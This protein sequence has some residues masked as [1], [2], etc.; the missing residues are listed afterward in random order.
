MTI[1]SN[2]IL[3]L[4]A[5]GWIARYLIDSIKTIAPEQ[6]IVGTYRNNKPF[7]NIKSEKITSGDFYEVKNLIIETNPYTVVN[8]TRGETEADL[9]FHQELTKYLAQNGIYYVYASSSNATDAIWN[10]PYTESSEGNAKSDYGIFK[11][12]CEKVLRE[13]SNNYVAFRFAATHGFAPNRTSRT[14]IFLQKLYAGEIVSVNG[15]IF[16]NR[17]YISDLTNMMAALMF[18]KAQGIIHLGTIDQ[19]EEFEFLNKLALLFGYKDQVIPVAKE[20]NLYVSALP[21]KMFDYLDSSYRL[22]EKDTFDKLINVPE[23]QKYWKN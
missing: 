4:G 23:F 2:N 20:E 10:N 12:R 18:K 7:H 11:A 14:E 1:V 3:I 9:N 22:Q 21:I 19:S 8:L 13:N 5:S 17:T 6:F 15:G 16:Q